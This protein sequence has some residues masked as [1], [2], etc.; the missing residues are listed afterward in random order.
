[1]KR[2]ILFVLCLLWSCISMAQ[3]LPILEKGS[4][5]QFP[6]N[7]NGKKYLEFYLENIQ[8]SD[9]TIESCQALYTFKVTSFG[10]ETILGNITSSSNKSVTIVSPYFKVSNGINWGQPIDI[11]SMSSNVIPKDSSIHIQFR[12]EC[13]S[14]REGDFYVNTHKVAYTNLCYDGRIV[15]EM[16]ANKKRN[17]WA[18]NLYDSLAREFTINIENLESCGQERM[19]IY[20]EYPEPGNNWQGESYYLI[21]GKSIEAHFRNDRHKYDTIFYFNKISP[22]LM[23]RYD[24]ELSVC[25]QERIKLER[26]DKRLVELRNKKVTA[27]DAR[28]VFDYFPKGIDIVEFTRRMENKELAVTPCCYETTFYDKFEKKDILFQFTFSDTGKLSSIKRESTNTMPTNDVWTAFM[29]V[30][31]IDTFRD[32]GKALEILRRDKKNTSTKK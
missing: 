24:E 18:Q 6:L 31:T 7:K 17:M 4:S 27:I 30:E 10:I 14:K 15:R 16:L 32:L 22:F 19:S 12:L 8:Y 5:F 2:N 13:F 1:M 29:L 9:S 23:G 28:E 20:S 26:E 25:L 3:A 21:E 11:I